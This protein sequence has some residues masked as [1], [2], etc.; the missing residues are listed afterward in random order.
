MVSIWILQRLLLAQNEVD[1]YCLLFEKFENLLV[2]FTGGSV[3]EWIINFAT[4]PKNLIQILNVES[5]N[6]EEV[7]ILKLWNHSETNWKNLTIKADGASIDKVD[8]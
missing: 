3:G 5:W 8:M 2:F 4:V 6:Q 7:L 1:S